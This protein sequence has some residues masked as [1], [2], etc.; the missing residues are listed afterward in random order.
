LNIEVIAEDAR[1]GFAGQM[2]DRSHG[3][4]LIPTVYAGV[5]NLQRNVPGAPRG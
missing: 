2:S 5:L 4:K 3:Q 1:T